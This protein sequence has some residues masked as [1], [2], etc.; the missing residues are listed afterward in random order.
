MNKKLK[1]TMDSGV[2]RKRLKKLS[3]NNLIKVYNVKIEN[4]RKSKNDKVLPI[5]VFGE[6]NW[7]ECLWTSVDMCKYYNDIIK[8]IGKDNIKDALILDAHYR[9]N[10][11]Y[12]V[13]NNPKDFIYN[14]KR[15]K[16]ENKLIGLKIVIIDELEKICKK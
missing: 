9:N 7:G 5:G 8:I 1:V 15:N 16:L 14:D 2:D 3:D 6:C 11:D 13:T 10:F 12:F 4:G